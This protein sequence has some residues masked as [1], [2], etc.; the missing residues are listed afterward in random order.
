MDYRRL[1]RLAA[2]YEEECELLRKA[3]HKERMLQKLNDMLTSTHSKEITLRLPREPV[4]RFL[5][6]KHL[7]PTFIC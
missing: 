1:K 7:H 3:F 2:E 4:Q 6:R 5:I